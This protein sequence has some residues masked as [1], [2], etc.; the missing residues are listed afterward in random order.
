MEPPG[1]RAPDSA[2]EAARLLQRKAVHEWL[3]P[4]PRDESTP[5]VAAL[6]LVDDLVA[7]HVGD[8][9]RALRAVLGDRDHEG[10][11][12]LLGQLGMLPALMLMDDYKSR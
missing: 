11:D 12:G 9:Q 3:Q 2:G 5:R 10:V 1:A 4:F 8:Q 7:E 6:L